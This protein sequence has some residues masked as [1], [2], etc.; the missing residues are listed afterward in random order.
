VDDSPL[1]TERTGK[2]A[3]FAREPRLSRKPHRFIP[4]CNINQGWWDLY[5]SFMTCCRGPAGLDYWA[6]PQPWV[7]PAP[8]P[9]GPQ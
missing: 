8:P 7:Y 5:Y 6:T 3:Q 1:D 2:D 9:R 4:T